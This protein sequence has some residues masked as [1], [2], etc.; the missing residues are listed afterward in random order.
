MPNNTN[1][2]ATQE[3]RLAIVLNLLETNKKLS[4]AKDLQGM[5][6]VVNILERITMY[7]DA[8]ADEQRARDQQAQM[9]QEQLAKMSQEAKDEAKAEAAE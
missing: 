5:F 4:Q 7:P 3:V 6:Q 2:T 8:E 1:L 9:L